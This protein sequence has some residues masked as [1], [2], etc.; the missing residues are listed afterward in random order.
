MNHNYYKI[1]GVNATANIDDIKAAYRKLAMKH[2]PDRNPKDKHAEERFKKIN[3]AYETLKDPQLRAQYN[4]SLKTPQY[5]TKSS[6]YQE[7]QNRY[8]YLWWIIGR[9]IGFAI[10]ACIFGTIQL[11]SKFIFWAINSYVLD[12]LSKIYPCV[13][14]S[15][16]IGILCL[17]S[18]YLSLPHSERAHFVKTIT[19]IMKV[20]LFILFFLGGFYFHGDPN[21]SHHRS[22]LRTVGSHSSKT[23]SC[24]RTTSLPKTP[25]L[26]LGR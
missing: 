17:L 25:P 12:N 24:S 22:S 11:I 14:A 1:L 19:E 26:R 10:A 18:S 23:N 7:K 5:Q 13:T 4:Q 9:I 8:S 20:A 3:A 16:I 2:H 21:R 6:T 15:S